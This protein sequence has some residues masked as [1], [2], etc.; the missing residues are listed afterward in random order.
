MDQYYNVCQGWTLTQLPDQ[1]LDPGI[2]FQEF[3]FFSHGAPL[4][5]LHSSQ[6]ATAGLCCSAAESI[7]RREPGYTHRLRYSVHVSTA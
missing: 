4:F 7:V 5:V 6:P 1:S 2:F 3:L